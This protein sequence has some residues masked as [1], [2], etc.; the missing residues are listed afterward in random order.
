MRWAPIDEVLLRSHCVYEETTC[1][2]QY[3]D[4]SFMS[5]EIYLIKSSSVCFKVQKRC[6][7]WRGAQR[8]LMAFWVALCEQ[9]SE[10]LWVFMER[11]HKLQWETMIMLLCF[12]SSKASSHGMFNDVLK[13]LLRI[14]SGYKIV[15]KYY[16]LIFTLK[17]NED[18]KQVNLN[19]TLSLNQTH[20]F[21]SHYK[22]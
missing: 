3:S 22:C 21:P 10:C 7:L 2:N 9:I 16:W 20:H 5:F 18:P 12:S 14:G 17:N 4:F 15:E 8:W 19:L 13:L 11:F 1:F 6:S